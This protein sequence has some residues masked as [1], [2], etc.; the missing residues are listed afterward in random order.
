M[1]KLQKKQKL[2]EDELLNDPFNLFISATDIRF[3]YFKETKN[4]LG[5]TYGMLVVQ[6]FE[7]ITP[8]ILARTIETVEGGGMIIFLLPKMNSLKQLYTMAMDVHARFRTESQH[9]VVPRFNER[10][11]LSL[12]TCKSWFVLKIAY[13]YNCLVWCW[14]IN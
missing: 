6:D 1:K 7:A 4:I 10:F 11:L 2:E 12:T 8:N 5:N 3:C 9:D 14:M 13:I